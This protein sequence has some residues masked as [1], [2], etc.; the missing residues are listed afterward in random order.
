MST[1]ASVVRQAR[2]ST[3]TAGRPDVRVGEPL[4]RLLAAGAILDVVADRV[5]LHCAELIGQ[6]PAELIRGWTGLEHRAFSAPMTTQS[7]SG[8]DPSRRRI[9]SRSILCT[10]LLAL[11]TVA[12]LMPQPVGHGRAG[13]PLDGR[14]TK[15]LPGMRLDPQPDP[16]DG[17]VEQLVIE[18]LVEQL[19]QVVAGLHGLE[20]VRPLRLTAAA[21]EHEPAAGHEVAPGMVGQRPQPASEAEAGVVGERFHLD[22]ERCQDG[23]GHVL[24]VRVLQV[25]APAPAINPGAVAIDELAPGLLVGGLVAQPS[26]QGGAGPEIRSV[27]HGL[28]PPEEQRLDSPNSHFWRSCPPIPHGPDSAVPP[29]P[30]HHQCNRLA[31]RPCRKC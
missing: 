29:N 19:H 7:L 8:S 14:E 17:L 21:H 4:Q 12:T 3:A 13:H 24:G 5:L 15:R 10:L 28:L 26:Q 11:K 23:L 27:P 1:S 2:C 20:P 30:D 16:D 31:A 18:L 6:Q 22:A 25:P 9:S